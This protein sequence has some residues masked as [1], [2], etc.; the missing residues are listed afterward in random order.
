MVVARSGSDAPA[1][2]T[3]CEAT[4]RAHTG[5]A[6][7]NCQ[8]EVRCGA[9]SLYGGD[10]GYLVCEAIPGGFRALDAMSTPVDTDPSAMIDTVSRRAFVDTGLRAPSGS[11]TQLLLDDAT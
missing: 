9:L 4:L 1:L 3:R 10:A 5:H 6:T 2:G 11:S 8:L 7:F